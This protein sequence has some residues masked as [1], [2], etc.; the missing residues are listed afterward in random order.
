MKKKLPVVIIALLMATGCG[1][2]PMA[3]KAKEDAKDNPGMCKDALKDTSVSKEGLDLNSDS[4]MYRYQF[5]FTC[6][7]Q[8]AIRNPE[9]CSDVL[10]AGFPK[11]DSGLT[12]NQNVYRI[13]EYMACKDY[14]SSALER[15]NISLIKLDKGIYE[16]SAEGKSNVVIGRIA[17][18][19][20]E[21]KSTVGTTGGAGVGAS[22]GQIAY[23]DNTD[24]SSGYSPW[25]Q[26]G[27][28]IAGAA[29]GSTMDQPG[30]VK[31]KITYWIKTNS[32]DFI[33]FIHNDIKPGYLPESMCV[34]IVNNSDI[35]QAKE[36]LCEKTT[37]S[38]K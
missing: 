7:E 31:F 12:T 23:L 28:G 6:L 18:V 32:G 37:K 11:P 38:K 30:K 29:I 34:A 16:G 9:I 20:I 14:A 26:I 24:L 35:Q 27:A 5:Y 10:A 22:V 3:I 25:K 2:H 15:K 13:R 19:Q 4:S 33:S 36:A 17:S 8:E 21:D 1:P